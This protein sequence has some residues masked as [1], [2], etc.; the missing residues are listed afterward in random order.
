MF[1]LQWRRRSSFSRGIVWS[2]QAPTTAQRCLFVGIPTEC[3]LWINNRWWWSRLW[4]DD[5]SAPKLK[6]TLWQVAC[7]SLLSLV[8]LPL[9]QLFSLL[10]KLGWPQTDFTHQIFIYKSRIRHY[11]SVFATSWK[12]NKALSHQGSRHSGSSPSCCVLSEAQILPGLTWFGPPCPTNTH[13]QSECLWISVLHIHLPESLGQKQEVST[14]SFLHET[15]PH[16]E[17]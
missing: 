17:T 3:W 5:L 10:M 2:P 16:K 12:M 8:L 1:G 4:C 14:C 13:T 7:F 15:T 11:W 6:K 9:N